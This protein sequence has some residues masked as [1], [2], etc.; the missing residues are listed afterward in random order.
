[1]RKL[2][3]RWIRSLLP[4]LMLGATLSGASVSFAPIRVLA[5]DGPPTL[6]PTAQLFDPS[7]IPIPPF[8]PGVVLVGVRGDVVASVSTWGQTGEQAATGNAPLDQTM[9]DAA[10]P[11]SDLGVTAV[12]PLDLRTGAVSA[13]SEDALAGYKLTVPT[14]TEWSVIENL[15]TH[16]EVVFAEPNWL[17]QVA[18]T[19]SLQTAVAST[20]EATVEAPFSVAD[21]L[22]SEQ[23]YLQRIGMGR[24]WSVALAEA[25]GGLDTIDVTVIDTG[26]DFNH[27]DFV[28]RL[29]AGKNYLSAID[30]PMDDNGHGTHISGLIAAA[31]NNGG[32]V[33][34][35]WQVR[36]N[37]LKALDGNGFGGVNGIAQAI[38]DAT[39]D[40]AHI[41]NLSLTLDNDATVL[42]MAIDYAVAG[43]V[44]VI[45]A[46]G[47]QGHTGNPN[48][49]YPAAYESV[50]AVGST[51]YYD[52]RAYYSNR[53][54]ALDIMAPGGGSGTSILSTWSSDP[55]AS[56]ASGSRQVNGGLYCS[57]DGTSMATAMVS[58]IAALVWS[59]RPELDADEVRDILLESAAPITGSENE[60]GQGRA[61]A[62]AAIRLALPPQL[63]LS[64]STVSASSLQNDTPIV[65]SLPLENS[66]AEPVT[67]EIARTSEVNW[68]DV[69]EPRQ[70]EV[71]YGAPAAAQV[72][73]TPT[74]VGV[75]A[76]LGQ[77]QVTSTTQDGLKTS[78]TVDARLDVANQVRDHVHLLPWVGGRSAS[79]TWAEPA[80]TGR[81]SYL[82][83][84]DGSIVVELPFTMTVNGRSYT[85][86]RIFADGFAVASASAFPANAPTH[87]L[88]NQTWPAFAVYGWWSE[89]SLS[90]E[91][92]L[93]T[94]QPNANSFVI[95]YVDMVSMGSSNP[96]DRVSFQ[97][98][99][100]RNGTVEL[101]YEQVPEQKPS[102]LTVGV[103]ALDGRFYNQVTCHAGTLV[104]GEAPAAHQSFLFQPGDL[105]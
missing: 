1:M 100:Y 67:W 93:S 104:I 98:V 84:A 72:V 91:S 69:L 81:T 44:L 55:G 88:A 30:T 83:T 64:Q 70:G 49:R 97:I 27:P 82:F 43:G 39:D 78:Y 24:A 23:W 66:S 22:Y 102:M 33:G 94:F 4:L 19:P 54:P 40:G 6:E 13:A 15:L 101:N 50:L 8:V 80:H 31:A 29:G 14:G 61:D 99:L 11:W 53:G 52:G 46:A 41:I 75:G 95:E 37:P 34:T 68:Y 48:V 45:A 47:N 42:R 74:N 58:G 21:T 63:E 10:L 5:Q 51:T 26:V 56:C 28:N 20:V 57:V 103:S 32:M 59:L 16:T 85:D 36:I 76:H 17:A 105:Y 7:V 38:R 35:G 77:L 89:L 62:A 71:S 96:N 60:V 79:Y 92:A 18:V 9:P 3:N 65:V 90:Q 87:C 73:F 2:I 86:L 25:D 12:E